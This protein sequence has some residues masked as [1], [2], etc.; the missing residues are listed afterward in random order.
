MTGNVALISETTHVSLEELTIVAAAIQKQ[1]SR[2]LGPTWNLS[3]TVDAF[4]AIQDVPLG[5][6]HV[7]VRDDIAID[8]AGIHQLDATRQPYALVRWAP[9][10]SL[11]ASHEVLEML[12]DPFGNRLV[13]GDSPKTDQGRVLFLVEVC[14]PCQSAAYGYAVNGVL[15]SDFCLPEY[16][17]PTGTSGARYCFSGADRKSTRLNSSH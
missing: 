7:L 11:T 6:W 13:A 10:W 8:D 16:F 4:G 14:D 2:D 12:V 15:V 5:Y 3:A 1:V 17:A 9:Q